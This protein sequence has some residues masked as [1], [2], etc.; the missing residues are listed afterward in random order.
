M[1]YCIGKL[2]P[3]IGVCDSLHRAAGPQL[4]E[5]VS[6]LPQPFLGDDPSKKRPLQVGETYFTSGYQVT[7]SYAISN[8]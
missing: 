4:R 7:L 2:P 1:N 5:A 6:K 8:P 3:A